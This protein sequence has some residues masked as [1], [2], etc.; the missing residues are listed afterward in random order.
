MENQWLTIMYL[1]G[2]NLN[3]NFI[4]PARWAGRIKPTFVFE[5]LFQ[6]LH[7]SCFEMFSKPFLDQRYNR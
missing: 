1:M 2:V 7:V 5:P 4:I 6:I 3:Y